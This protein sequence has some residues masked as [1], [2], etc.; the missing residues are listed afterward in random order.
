MEQTKMKQTMEQITEQNLR[1]LT[2]EQRGQLIAQKYRIRR[3]DKGYEVLCK[4]IAH[5]ICCVILEMNEL[6]LESNFCLKSQE[7][8]QKV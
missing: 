8:A 5:N 7:S 3:T 6:G 2:R 4:I 1:N